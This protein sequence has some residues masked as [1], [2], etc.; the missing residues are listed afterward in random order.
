M[1]STG[2]KGFTFVEVMVTLVVLSAGIVFIYRTFFLCVDYLSRLSSR[3]HANEL[4]DEKMSEI[5]LLFRE[6]GSPAFDRG[7]SSVS[8]SIEGRDVAFNYTIAMDPLEG[9][10]GLYRLQVD[11]AWVD[12]GRPAHFSRVGVL[13]L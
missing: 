1:S 12:A 3:I 13:G 4:V 6:Q 9:Q 7:P 10:E 2:N 5:S 11:V 8:R